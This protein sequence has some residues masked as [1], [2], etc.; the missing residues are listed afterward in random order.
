MG[1][2]GTEFRRGGHETI[3]FRR[4]DR[5][6]AVSM[7]E[8]TVGQMRALEPDRPPAAT[9]G[10]PDRPAAGVDWFAAAR[11]CNRLS[12]AAKIDRGQWCYPEQTKGGMEVP[13]AATGKE[14]FRLPTEAEW[15]YICRAGTETARPYGESPQLL[16]RYAWTWRNSDDFAHPA[17]GLLPNEFGMFDVLGN[18]W[19]WCHDGPDRWYEE[20]G[21]LRPYPTGTSRDRPAGD[22]GHLERVLVEDGVRAMWRAL[23]GGAFNYAP[24]KA[25]S[26]HRDWMPTTDVVSYVGFRVVRT[27]PRSPAGNAPADIAARPA[28]RTPA[29][30]GR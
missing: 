10:D 18:V 19:E 13:A 8:V 17:G 15:E 23:R 21:I 12:A 24:W 16:D 30:T 14:G 28:E 6:L 9:A 3:N 2:P 22:P 26:A 5:S 7:T 27:W 29:R 20:G 4:I 25:R 1:S 11:Y